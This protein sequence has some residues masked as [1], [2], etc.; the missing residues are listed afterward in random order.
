MP[1]RWKVYRDNQLVGELTSAEIRQRL[2]DGGLDPFDQVSREG[3]AV[4]MEILDVDE[5]FQESKIASDSFLSGFDQ[6][7][8]EEHTIVSQMP[9]K[10]SEAP[11]ARSHAK[12]PQAPLLDSIRKPQEN[13]GSW[14][15]PASPPPLRTPLMVQSGAFGRPQNQEQRKVKEY[16]LVDKQNRRLGPLSAA[17]IQ[18]LFQRGILEPKLLVQ[19]ISD[20]SR[21]PLRQFLHAFSTE[22]IAE[23]KAMHPQGAVNRGNQGSWNVSALVNQMS[24]SVAT[25]N[26]MKRQR[27]L[28]Y[29]L[30]LLLGIMMGLGSFF[31]MEIR[32]VKKE[33]NEQS[34]QEEIENPA[35]SSNIP[36]L[37]KSLEKRP[38]ILSL[39]RSAPINPAKQPPSK[40][41]QKR[42]PINRTTEAAPPTDGK[43]ATAKPHKKSGAKAPTPATQPLASLHRP[44]ADRPVAPPAKP[45]P[46]TKTRRATP[47]PDDNGNAAET[48]AKKEASASA[49]TPD[50]NKPASET[51]A[52]RRPAA[53]STPE[54]AAPPAPAAAPSSSSGK[55]GL[56][57]LAG[58][59]DQVVT[60]SAVR[61]S[62]A[63]LEQ[64]PM[65][66]SL[67]F[68][69]S[70]GETF[71]GLFF[72]GAFA[73]Q[74]VAK[75]GSAKLLGRVKQN[76]KLFQVFVQG[77]P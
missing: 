15:A 20:P 26:M 63:A 75:G 77:I 2:R 4:R 50:T 46:K 57:E 67:T 28:Y 42:A 41:S 45:Y 44:Q 39:K 70:N 69:Y 74:L 14:E 24:R 19:K 27:T 12:S 53:S 59:V 21:I 31:A 49:G 73:E 38:P 71:T 10:K 37:A 61:Y 25:M 76:G 60:T 13:E 72:K 29:T 35:G 18:S 3:S 33:R 16:F 23:V 55:V 8:G 64:C 54:P 65:K 47:L 17:E 32:K 11:P 9:G 22:Q 56:A 58:T 36:S 6:A 48:P 30:M 62:T 5:I 66:C 68:T 52:K 1:A 43:K 51:P 40:M 7:A 34:R